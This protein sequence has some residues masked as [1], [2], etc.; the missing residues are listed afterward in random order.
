MAFRIF[1]ALP[2]KHTGLTHCTKTWDMVYSIY[3]VWPL[4]LP[5]HHT[6]T[7]QAFLLHCHHPTP[8]PPT[9]TA[10]KLQYRR[11]WLGVFLPLHHL[12]RALP[13]ATTPPATARLP[14]CPAFRYA[15][16]MPLLPCRDLPRLLH[17]TTFANTSNHP[18]TGR[19]AGRDS[20]AC[21]TARFFVD[22]AS[23][24]YRGLHSFHRGQDA[25]FRG[26]NRRDPTHRTCVL[27]SRVTRE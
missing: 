25:R 18:G 13:T 19:G 4:A 20:A 6:A 23:V 15:T 7:G 27:F 1:A 2:N 14:T 26:R 10:Q 3:Q 11:A 9:P 17:T 16:T 21:G 12:L 5:C 8:T 24:S 22:V